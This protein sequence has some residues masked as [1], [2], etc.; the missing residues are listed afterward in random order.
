MSPTTNAGT[1]TGLWGRS[2]ILRAGFRH[3]LLLHQAVSEVIKL[4]IVAK[5]DGATV[6]CTKLPDGI[7]AMGVTSDQEAHF[8]ADQVLELR[9]RAGRSGMFPA[10]EGSGPRG[11]ASARIDDEDPTERVWR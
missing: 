7:K 2:H 3:T 6:T 5:T 10:P 11:Y 1:F 8:Q 4:D 9:I